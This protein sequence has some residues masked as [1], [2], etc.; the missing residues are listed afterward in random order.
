MSIAETIS[1]DRL[2]GPYFAGDSWARWRAVLKA[3]Q[4]EPPASDEERDLFRDVADREW[5]A[6]PVD[7]L[8]AVI[9]RGG[10]KNAAASALAVHA[11][12][13]VD[14]VRLRPGEYPAIFCFAT[15]RRQARITK[16]Y[17]T[18]LFEEVPLL[19]A[20]VAENTD[21][22]LVLKN[23]A[24]IIIGTANHRA[25]RGRTIACAIMDEACFWRGEE[26]AS[27][28]IE[29]DAAI[30]P[31]LARHPGSIK[32]MISSAYT[33]DGLV[34]DRWK[35]HYGRDTPGILCVSGTTRQFNPSFPEAVIERELAKDYPR[36]AAEYL[37]IWRDDLAGFVS[38]PVLEALIDP[39]ATERQYDRRF[40]YFAYSDDAGGSMTAK[41]ASTFCIAHRDPATDRVVQD[42]LRWWDPP[43]NA[44]QVMG[45]KAALAKLF[46]L[47]TITGDNWG[48]GLTQTVYASHGMTYE[49]VTA[50]KSAL[51]S[52]F[53]TLVNSGQPL[54][55]N[56]PLMISQF[57]ALERRISFGSRTETIDHPP[58]DNFHDDLSNATA[59]ACVLAAAEPGPLI[60]TKEMIEHARRAR[61]RRWRLDDF[62]SIGSYYF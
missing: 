49:K 51:Y 34:Y 46:G 43:F 23:R 57:V 16:N 28:D 58:R 50:N 1:D 5:P 37:S 52:D 61:P 44:A 22:G 29:V 24:E 55:L 48:A 56:V 7:E 38:R 21:D 36:Y 53:L 54:L 25:P 32:I 17:I 4:G 59:G 31:G 40:A 26:S 45:E 3:C 9:G 27:P 60:I 41:D 19:A 18:A 6:A 47:S 35:A 14:P 11:A 62:R 33:R 10:G 12:L 13:S 15:D 39:L 30:G 20:T 2:L 42:V 8:I